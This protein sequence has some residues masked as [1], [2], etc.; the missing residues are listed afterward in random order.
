[1]FVVAATLLGAGAANAK[2]I[3]VTSNA[4]AGLNTLRAAIDTVRSGGGGD[5]IV[6][7]P[8]LG[9]ITLSTFS[10]VDGGSLYLLY[11]DQSLTIKGNGVI[12]TSDVTAP[13]PIYT[14]RTPGMKVTIERVHFKDIK[15]ETVIFNRRPLTLKA[16]I[17]SGNKGS[18]Y[19][20][21]YNDVA[22][23]YPAVYG[24]TNAYGCTFVDNAFCSIYTGADGAADI[25]TLFGN[26]FQNSTLEYVRATSGID[27]NVSNKEVD[28][29]SSVLNYYENSDF[30]LELDALC[31]PA[32]FVPSN[33]IPVLLPDNLYEICPNYPRQDFY[34]TSIVSGWSVVGAVVAEPSDAPALDELAVGSHKLSPEFNANTWEY[35]VTVGPDVDS[36]TITATAAEGSVITPADTAGVR[37]LVDGENPP[38]LIHVNKENQD[39]RFYTL[40]VYRESDNADLKS[41]IV[42]APAS[43]PM[44]LKPAFDKDTLEYTVS[45][46]AETNVLIKATPVA[47][48]ASVNGNGAV[49]VPATKTADTLAV[50]V[51]A[52]TS[53][54]EKVYTLYVTRSATGVQTPRAALQVHPNP[55]D[56]VVYIDNPDST[57]VRVYALNGSVVIRKN[58]GIVDMSGYPAGVYIIKVGGKV[59]KVVKH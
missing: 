18:M 28:F 1:M 59:A 58:T 42:E 35:D 36:I 2:I 32:T 39:E 17:F 9:T 25:T 14:Y 29:Q 8:G 22:T 54:K 38:F 24:S 34:G 7:Q 26:I 10:P 13:M 4:D 3:P 51:V 37:V 31:D 30:L 27:Y 12:I 33:E 50:V 57:K 41:L 6:V 44:T 40:N 43:V 20:L 19:G 55:T 21:I 52:E 5:T 53:D 49:V 46:G 56:G 23:T 48:R 11:I 45:I 16:C 15:A 47:D